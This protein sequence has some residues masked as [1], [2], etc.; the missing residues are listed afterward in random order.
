M[1]VA[2]VFGIDVTEWTILSRSVKFGDA[3]KALGKLLEVDIMLDVRC[4][5]PDPY[6]C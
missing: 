5:K 3:L 1:Y 2:I 4:D 6:V